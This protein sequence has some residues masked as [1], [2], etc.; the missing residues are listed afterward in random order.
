M[1]QSPPSTDQLAPKAPASSIEPFGDEIAA[2]VA[3][4]LDRDGHVLWGFSSHWMLKKGDRLVYELLKDERREIFASSQKKEFAAWL[5]K[6]S[7]RSLDDHVRPTCHDTI[8]IITHDVLAEAVASGASV[9][10]PTPYGI[11]LASQVADALDR[12]VTVTYDHRDYCGMGLARA[13]ADYLYGTV[14]DGHLFDD[15]VFASREALV[16]WL[17]QQ[18]DLALAGREASSPFYWNNQRVTRAR[19]LEANANPGAM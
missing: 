13:G 19:L 16:A 10:D 15:M 8:E 11:A 3:D 17:A 4:L 2:G 7:P 9:N 5:A 6:Q 18:S 1:S 14:N 12:G